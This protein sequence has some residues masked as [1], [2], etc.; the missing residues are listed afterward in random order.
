MRRK[1]LN[2]IM[3]L[4]L[5][6]LMACGSILPVSAAGPALYEDYDEL[7]EADEGV[8]SAAAKLPSTVAL[9]KRSYVYSGSTILP[10][11]TVKEGSRI[12]D[13]KYYSIAAVRGDNA[14]TV[15]SHKATIKFRS[16]YSGSKTFSYRIVPKG[17]SLGTLS[18]TQNS[19]SVKYYKQGVQTSG[20]QIQYSSSS[21]F[22]NAKSVRV[23]K[24]TT[25]S[26]KLTG[27]S[28]S[29]KY[30]VRVRTYKTVSGN[31]Y[32]SAWSKAKSIT[33]KSDVPVNT[34]TVDNLTFER[35]IDLFAVAG[36]P[37]KSWGPG[38]M[39]TYLQSK[40]AST[41]VGSYRQGSSQKM[42]VYTQSGYALGMYTGSKDYTQELIVAGPDCWYF[43]N[44]YIGG[45]AAGWQ[46]YN[47][48]YWPNAGSRSFM[49]NEK[50]IPYISKAISYRH[51]V[52]DT[53]KNTIDAIC[54][55]LY[56]KIARGQEYNGN[57]FKASYSEKD[58][59]RLSFADNKYVY[60]K[61]DDSKVEVNFWIW[62]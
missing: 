15:G 35:V 55:G 49:V 51:P 44:D 21:S 32:Y 57:N 45:S 29:K 20:Y 37:L 18:S 34:N 40:S 23:T 1:C 25:L 14:R 16:P 38:S 43:L 26:K 42:T 48:S 19:I 31:N 3:A 59:V 60:I 47:A 62:K 28:S 58:G 4:T 33:T 46:V 53:V 36:K 2:K 7:L 50:K 54:P 24:N 30:Y 5:A 52:K 39:K 11:F 17:T 22:K 56:S 61:S 6:G 12:V 8:E 13:R 41:E 9:T 27:L 10:G